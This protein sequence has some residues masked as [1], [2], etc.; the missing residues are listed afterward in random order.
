MSARSD[1]QTPQLES[2]RPAGICNLSIMECNILT[3]ITLLPKYWQMI[4]LS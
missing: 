4:I 2:I 3:I 1:F